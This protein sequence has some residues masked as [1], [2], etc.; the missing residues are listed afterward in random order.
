MVGLRIAATNWWPALVGALLLS[1]QLIGL[2]AAQEPTQLTELQSDNVWRFGAEGKV[3]EASPRQTDE[4][5]RAF[6]AAGTDTTTR[7]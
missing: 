6:R 3:V 5:E 1:V 4:V 2:A 7:I